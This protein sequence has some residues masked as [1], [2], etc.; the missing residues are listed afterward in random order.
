MDKMLCL[1]GFRQT[2]EA[3]LRT[4]SKMKK[5]TDILLMISR[6]AVVKKANKASCTMTSQH[7]F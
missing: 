5:I 7:I 1:R 4:W 6:A 3:Q 2:T